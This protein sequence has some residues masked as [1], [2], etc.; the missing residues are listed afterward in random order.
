MKVSQDPLIKY[1]TDITPE[2]LERKKK[3]KLRE[4]KGRLVSPKESLSSLHDCECLITD[5]EREP[6]FPLFLIRKTAIE[7]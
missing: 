7:P 2:V 5:K 3:M 1:I 4:W 6:N